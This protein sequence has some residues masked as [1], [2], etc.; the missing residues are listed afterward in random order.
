LIVS[1]QRF[2]VFLLMLASSI[3]PAAADNAAVQS[4]AVQASNISGRWEVS[5]QARLG[6]DQAVVELQQSGSKLTG[7][8]RDPHHTCP[9]S[10]TIDGKNISFE[11]EFQAARPY[12]I[13]FKGTVDGEKISGTSQAQNVGGKGAYLGHGGE[14]VQPEHPWTATRPADPPTLK[15]KQAKPNNSGSSN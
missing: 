9:L 1:K 7:T 6:T 11:V 8:F 14:I 2:F 3:L 12:T 10:G 13:G 4:S 5:W 15:S